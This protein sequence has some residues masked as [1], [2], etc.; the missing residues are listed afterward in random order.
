[1]RFV[2]FCLGLLVLVALPAFAW[3]QGNEDMIYA[4]PLHVRHFS[5]VIV[6]QTGMWVEYATVELLDPKSHRVLASTFSDGNGFFYFDDK[7]Y[8]KRIQIHAFK[9]GF[10]ASQY[11]AMRRPFG[12]VHMRLV[13]HVAT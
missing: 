11:T 5:G 13:L 3:A 9:S 6:D 12:D 2:R 10:D 1:M 8:G 7:K 4:R